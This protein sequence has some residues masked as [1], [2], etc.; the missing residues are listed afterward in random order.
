VI[1]GMFCANCIRPGPDLRPREQ[2]GVMFL[3]CARCDSEV[4]DRGHDFAPGKRRWTG[5]RYFPLDHIE[6]ELPIRILRTLRR[7]ESASSMELSD[8]LQIASDSNDPVGR[9]NYSV[10]LSRLCRD[11]YVRAKKTRAR[12]MKRSQSKSKRSDGFHQWK[13]YSITRLGIARLEHS[14]GSTMASC[15]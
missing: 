11:G 12:A 14:L 7:F 15:Y 3:F 2:D 10:T 9:N 13:E 6:C 1:A 5:S 4:E 8:V